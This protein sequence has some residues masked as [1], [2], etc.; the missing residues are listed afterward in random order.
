MIFFLL[1][2]QNNIGYN[3][4]ILLWRRLPF[5]L[6]FVFIGPYYQQSKRSRRHWNNN[7]KNRVRVMVLKA[8]FNNISVLSWWSVLLVEETGENYDLY[9]VTDK[10][11]R[12][13][14]YRV[15]LAWAG[16]ELTTLVM[17]GTDC[18]DS[19]KSNYHTFTTMTATQKG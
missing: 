6:N 15:H 13:L 9:Q 14:L 11:Y 12:I 10:L 4:S 2:I 7:H 17:I 8:T 16:F 1:V 3:N 5:Q 18:T 19:C